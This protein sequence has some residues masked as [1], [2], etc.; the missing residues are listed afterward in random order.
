MNVLI[1]DDHKIVRD[2]VRLYLENH[3]LIESINEAK[4]GNEGLAILRQFPIDL[5]ILDINMEVMNGIET[6][7]SLKKEFDTIRVLA[8]TM[9]NDYQHIKSMMDAGASGYLLKNCEETEM[10]K[11]IDSVMNDEIYYSGEVAQTVMNNMAKKKVKT[12]NLIPLTRRESE[13]YELIL[14]EKSNQ[15]IADQLFIS[16]RTVEVHKRNLMEKTGAKNTAGLV[17]Y[18]VK[19]QLFNKF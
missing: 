13:I 6:A 10:H 17:L 12:S 3:P 11:A 15:E 5:V 14:E 19:N 9:H 7:K 1:I 8:L 2:G 18:A 16:I 4:N